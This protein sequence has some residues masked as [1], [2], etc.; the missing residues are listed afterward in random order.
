MSP[1]GPDMPNLKAPRTNL[2]PDPRKDPRNG[3]PDNPMVAP[4]YG[5]LGSFVG[6]CF[7][8]PFGGSGKLG[9]LQHL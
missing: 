4:T 7:L 6:V 2:Y 9:S 5:V 8:D 3:I 1:C